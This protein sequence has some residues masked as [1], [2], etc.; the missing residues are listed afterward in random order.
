MIELTD[1]I[2]ISFDSKLS[3]CEDVRVNSGHNYLARYFMPPKYFSSLAS[4]FLVY[5]MSE[6]M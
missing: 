1:L 3:E 2:T 5:E 4:L 6:T